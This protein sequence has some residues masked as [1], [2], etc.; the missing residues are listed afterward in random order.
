M[1]HCPAFCR[2][3]TDFAPLLLNLIFSALDAMA[4]SFNRVKRLHRWRLEGRGKM[5]AGEA[6]NKA[7]CTAEPNT[8][9]GAGP[10]HQLNVRCASIRLVAALRLGTSKSIIRLTIVLGLVGQVRVARKV[11]CLERRRIHSIWYKPCAR[12]RCASCAVLHAACL[13]KDNASW[14]SDAGGN[15]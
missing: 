6:R 11:G 14:L 9:N 5:F 7:T 1:P 8:C 13:D 10:P 12:R 4:K 2:L 15:Y 3:E